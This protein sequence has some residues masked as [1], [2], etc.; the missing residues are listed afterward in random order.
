[1]V[2]IYRYSNNSRPF[3]IVHLLKKHRILNHSMLVI[4]FHGTPAGLLGLGIRAAFDQ[5]W[6]SVVSV[7]DH[8]TSFNPGGESLPDELPNKRLLSIASPF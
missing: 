4:D 8:I 2:S 7:G 5:N 3:D 1:M 6:S